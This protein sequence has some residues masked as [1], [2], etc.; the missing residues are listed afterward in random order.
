MDKFEAATSNGLP[1]A[2][3][4]LWEYVGIGRQDGLKNHSERVRVQIP[5]FPPHILEVIELWMKRNRKLR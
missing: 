1:N 5:L 3:F 2:F 4:L